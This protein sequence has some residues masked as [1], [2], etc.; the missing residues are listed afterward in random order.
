MFS[1]QKVVRIGALW[2]ESRGRRDRGD[3]VWLSSPDEVRRP[4]HQTEVRPNLGLLWAGMSPGAM[5]YQF[6]HDQITRAMDLD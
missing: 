3:D 6:K 2:E 1:G 4:G 5:S